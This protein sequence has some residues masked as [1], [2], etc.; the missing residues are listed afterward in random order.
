L[1]FGQQ[2]LWFINQLAP[3]GAFYNQLIPIRLRGVL[4]R[5]ALQHAFDELVNRHEIL[6]TT[7]RAEGVEPVQLVQPPFSV[8]I[9]VVNMQLLS[10]V[11][12]REQIERLA[13]RE[14]AK[15]FD[16][17]RG[18]L[19]RL[20]LIELANDDYVLL[21]VVHHIVIDAWSL[22]VLQKE[23]A[24]LYNAYV[25]GNTSPPEPPPVQYSDYACG[26]VS[27]CL[28]QSSTGCWPTG[29]NSSP[30]PRRC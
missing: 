25:N 16:L 19:L 27:A 7:Y 6:R 10:E 12:G 9:H 15:P 4:D 22:A 13:S 3:D 1:S 18:P 11:E 20:H 21:V 28:A 30:A 23:L 24:I 8:E 29:R 5:R 14:V 2:R 17:R 26:S